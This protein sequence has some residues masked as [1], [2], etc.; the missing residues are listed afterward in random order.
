MLACASAPK[1][2]HPAIKV[3]IPQQWAA[4]T[5][6]PGAV[7]SLWWSDFGDA[8]LDSLVAEALQN[9]FD[10]QTAATRVDAAVAQARIIGAPLS[11]QLGM[12][13]NASRRKQIFVGFPIPG[14]K[15]VLSSIS[16]SFG[17]SLDVSW[18]L[19]LWGRLR[20]DKAAALADAQAAYADLSAAH[21]SLA[22]QTAKAWFA[23]IEAR[24]QV[25]LAEATVENFRHS[26]DQVRAR[27]DRGLRPSLDL[28]LSL[29]NLATAEDLLYQRRLQFEN[30]QRQLEV[31]LGRYPAA[32]LT[33]SDELP[34]MPEPVP[35][36]LP[37]EIVARRPD[38]VAME[39]RLAASGA[40]VAQARRAL[41]PRISLTS[42]TGTLSNEIKD[43]LNGD[44][45]VW[46]VLGN[47]LQPLFQGGRLRAGVA[48]ARAQSEQALAAYAQ[49]LLN[50]FAEIESALAAERYLAGR[51]QA[52][53]TATE[54]ALAARQLA[55]ER[56]Q[57]G[58]AELITVLESQR[59]AFE[60][61]SQLMAVRRQRLEA[62]V[63]LYLALGGGFSNTR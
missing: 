9:N 14:A 22:A 47:L 2:R 52:L 32:A 60:S 1:T 26:Y 4:G 27:Y 30:V 15:G 25:D 31:L 57:R 11:P 16:N 62:R 44:F 49:S 54:Q 35:A 6:A 19:D 20:A 58:L 46:S 21:L 10:L 42:S 37:L 18:E 23:A 45:L 8:R 29:S 12:D 63:D 17:V 28:R 39:R 24:H 50:A 53:E 41:Y 36:G 59:R 7:D 55:D 43:L 51:Q 48:L 61:E 3:E 40:R 56:Y 5:T 33:I 38:L 13:F 34:A